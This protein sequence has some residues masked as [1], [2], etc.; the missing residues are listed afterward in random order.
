MI[1]NVPKLRWYRSSKKINNMTDQQLFQRIIDVMAARFDNL[2]PLDS[3]NIDDNF[4]DDLAME[5]LD[6]VDL[7]MGI[8]TAFGVKLDMADAKNTHTI[9]DLMNFLKQ[10][11]PSLC[12]AQ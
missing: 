3:I 10:E 7:I 11:K 4:A 6:L 12:D 1:N 8:E 9:R 5:S 2:P